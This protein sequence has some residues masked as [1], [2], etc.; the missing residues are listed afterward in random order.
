MKIRWFYSHEASRIERFE[1][2]DGAFRLNERLQ[3]AAQE[4]TD[5]Q[6]SYL[7]QLDLMVNAMAAF[8]PASSATTVSGTDM[9]DVRRLYI[10]SLAGSV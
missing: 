7:V 6:A 2:A 1:F 9:E 5:E 3:P 8:S 10:N 4:A